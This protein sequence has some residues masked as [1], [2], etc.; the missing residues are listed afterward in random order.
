[1][2][3][4]KAQSDIISEMKNG[5]FLWTNEG[6]NFRA[7]LGDEKGREIKRIRVDSARVLL[8]N[9]LIK[10]KEGNYPMTLYKYEL[11]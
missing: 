3:I 9:K 10:Y 11:S 2:K 1:M 8:N 7:W 5:L 4:S 6:N